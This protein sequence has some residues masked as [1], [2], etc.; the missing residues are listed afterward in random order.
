MFA[1]A[2]TG[3]LASGPRLGSIVLDGRMWG[4]ETDEMDEMER[5]VGGEVFAYI[6]EIAT[7]EMCY[8][9]QR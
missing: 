3:A 6:F 7:L 5:M 1:G 2:G 8:K 9:I 4:N